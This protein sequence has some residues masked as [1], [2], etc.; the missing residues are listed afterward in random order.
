MRQPDFFGVADDPAAALR[1]GLGP[2]AVPDPPIPAS[3]LEPDSPSV[4]WGDMRTEKPASGRRSWPRLV[5]A[6]EIL[7]METI[8]QQLL[9]DPII[10]R[11][12]AWLCNGSQKAGKTLL[13]V[14]LALSVHAGNALF[15]YYRIPEAL[16]VL[17]IEQDDPSGVASLKEILRRSPLPI[18]PNRFFSVEHASFTFGPD[19]ILFLK[20]KIEDRGL[21]LVVLDSYTA[22]R[23]PR[24]A[25]GDIVKT[26]QTE[27]R[28]IDELAKATGCVILVLHHASKG[29]AKLDWSDRAAGTYAM[30]MA[31]EGQ[32]FISRFEDLPGNSPERLIQIRGRHVAGAEMVVRLDD[33]TLSY[34]FVLEGAAARM[35]PDMMQLRAAFGTVSF[36]PKG[37]C[38]ETGMSRATAHR[39][40]GRLV[41][42]GVLDRRGFGKYGFGSG[43]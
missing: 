41:S 30:G 11:P 14:Q 21:G 42:A 39:L 9:V 8:K 28:L 7:S 33:E 19:L 22:M 18:D 1:D 24:R 37:L 6:T 17:F 26:E 3:R 38:E 13:S 43:S 32:I 2:V 5:S 40:I 36:D 35:Y 27:L 10:T 31:T 29:S 4:D 15:D 12:G 34:Q 23:P 20:E 25:G 16:G